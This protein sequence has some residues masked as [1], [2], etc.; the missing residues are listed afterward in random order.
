MLRNRHL[1]FQDDPNAGA[2][3]GGGG[4]PPAFS[5][6]L[7]PEDLRGQAWAS[8]I[9][10][11]PDLFKQFDGAQRKIGE[12][13]SRVG[14]PGSDAADADWDAFTSK[15]RGKSEDYIV[16]EKEFTGGV[17]RDADLGKKLSQ[18]YMEVGLHPRQATAL[19]ARLDSLQDES[20]K[21]QYEEYQ[22]QETE[23]DNLLKG[24]FP[25]EAARTKGMALTK[26][27]VNEFA[28]KDLLGHLDSM[29]N[30]SMVMLASVLSKVAQKFIPED[31][32]PGISDATGTMET[33]EELNKELSRLTG[34]VNK[35]MP[36]KVQDDLMAKKT[37]IAKKLVNLRK[38][39]G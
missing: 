1:L 18:I 30:H 27:L 12:L 14:I 34:E 39:R 15:L 20:L 32:L 11:F 33:E 7:I 6:N 3:G 38:S 26:A 29:D 8:N 2:G 23:F 25:D 19:Q 21:A 36:G 24:V 22:K 35:L 5:P 28:P 17:K 13:G 10:D 31:Q 16:G 4:E 37:E 9:K